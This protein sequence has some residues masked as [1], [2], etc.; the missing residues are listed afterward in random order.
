MPWRGRRQRQRPLRARAPGC[1]GPAVATPGA[2]REQ[3]LPVLPAFEGLLPEPGLRRGTVTQTHGPGATSLALALLAGCTAEG[4]WVAAIGLRGLGL[5]AAGELGV[6]LSRLLL[7]DV[8]SR[9]AVGHRGGGR[10]GRGRRRPARGASSVPGGRRPP[11]PV[12]PA[13]SGGGGGP[14]RGGRP[15]PT[16]PGGRRGSAPVWH[17]FGLRLGAP[18]GPVP[19]GRGLGSPGGQPVPHRLGSGCRTPRRG[20]PGGVAPSRPGDRR[21]GR[22]PL[23]PLDTSRE[24]AS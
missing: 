3:V 24:A 15:V 21:R 7:V 4:S 13:G 23:R 6:V 9:A 20:P 22:R 5:A 8:P 17:G 11:P 2:G 19:A 1:G 14:G 18:A 10:A 12:P 16:G